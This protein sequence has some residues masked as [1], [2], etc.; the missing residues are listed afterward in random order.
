MKKAKPRD[1]L[2]T[3][4]LTWKLDTKKIPFPTSDS[5]K[6]C[7]EIIG[8]K[9]ALKAIQTGLDIKSMNRL[10]MISFMSTT[11]RILMNPL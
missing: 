6:A 9:R 3:A 2:S 1:G 11:S 4:R 8:Q 10:R 7:D 5:C